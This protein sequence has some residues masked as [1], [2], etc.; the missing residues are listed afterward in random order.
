[1]K[2]TVNLED[3]TFS[4]TN[5]H[6]FIRYVSESKDSI[7]CPETNFIDYIRKD[8]PEVKV[9]TEDYISE[10]CKQLLDIAKAMYTVNKQSYLVHT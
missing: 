8:N 3:I 2:V 5:C 6:K 7:I 9:Y 10:Y 4:R 1:M